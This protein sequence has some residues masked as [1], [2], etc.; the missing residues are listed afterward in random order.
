[1][2]NLNQAILLVTV[3]FASACG[4][5]HQPARQPVSVRVETVSSK[6]TDTAYSYTGTIEETSSSM[7]SFLVGG[8]LQQVWADAGARVKKGQKLASLDGS[9]L[10]DAYTAA[11]SNLERAED[12]YRRMKMLYD[13]GSLP[14]IKWVEVQTTL[15]EARS[16]ER[17]AA[18]NLRDA[19]L[20]APADGV[21][22]ER[23][24]DPGV[25]VAPGVPVLRL[26]QINKVYAVVS[27]PERD[28]PVLK[29]GMEASVSV[30]ALGTGSYAGVVAE[31][32][33]AANPLSH[34]YR[35]KI[36]LDN[37]NGELMPG[38]VCSVGIK[39]PEEISQIILPPSAVQ[40]DDKGQSFVWLARDGK[41]DKQIVM[42]GGLSGYGVIIASG[43]SDGDAVIV[44]GNQKVSQGMNIAAQ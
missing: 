8:T 10:A 33:V 15:S 14:E 40:I 6:N 9:S 44:E 26:V 16:V 17:I 36:E 38:M 42:P 31:K 34:T 1:M 4:S 23:Y 3:L 21:I 5:G 39:S 2:K 35:M 27:V 43:L 22:S 41:A 32:G 25:N 28:I 20:Y 19:V 30:G 11:K 29:T 37:P 24:A 7:L 12:A 18:K 13:A